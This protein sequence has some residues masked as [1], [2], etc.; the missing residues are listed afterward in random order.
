MHKLHNW[1]KLLSEISDSTASR[2][3]KTV[4]ELGVFKISESKGLGTF[5]ELN[6]LRHINVKKSGS[7][8]N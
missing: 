1:A 7:F 4:T 3:L 8:M 6:G 2:D 5:Y